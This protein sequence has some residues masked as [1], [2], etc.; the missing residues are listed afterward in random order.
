M[1]FSL[2]LKLLP[3]KGRAL[4]H[5]MVSVFIR[6]LLFLSRIRVK[7]SGLE[8]IPREKG[9]IFVGNHPG[10]LEPMYVMAHLP[11]RVLLVADEGILRIPLL[12]GVLKNLGCITY[13]AKGEDPG[14]VVSLLSALREGES[15][16]I[17]PR[18]LRYA[19]GKMRDLGDALL[20]TAKACQATLVPF[21]INQPGVE[22]LS[23]GIYV[24]PGETRVI[25][26]KPISYQALTPGMLDQRFRDLM[27]G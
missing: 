17:F 19:D 13:K 7:V 4:L 14:F 3:Q 6:I 25:V 27:G 5:S 11:V 21:V 12:G 1:V 24:T 8:N 9:L 23:K 10:L 15:V 18:S 16:L 20:R 2:P 26:G 22:S